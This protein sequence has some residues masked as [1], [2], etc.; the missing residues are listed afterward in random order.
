[1]K[2][3]NAIGDKSHYST[4]VKV[5]IKKNRPVIAHATTWAASVHKQGK[6][7]N[8]AELKKPDKPKGQLKTIRLY[9]YQF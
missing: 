6:R 4:E 9:L 2:H 1:M 7:L 3:F 8:W 5:A